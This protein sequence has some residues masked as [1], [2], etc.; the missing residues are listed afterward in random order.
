L[1]HLLPV[2]APNQYRENLMWVRLIHVDECWSAMA[3]GC[4]MLAYYFT[5]DCFVLS[6]VGCG[7]TRRQGLSLE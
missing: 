4:R 3:A 5:A 6:D 2:I 7:I 1:A